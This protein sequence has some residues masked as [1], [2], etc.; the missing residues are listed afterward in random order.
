M[1]T[2][3]VLLAEIRRRAE[4]WKAESTRRLNQ[5]RPDPVLC[6]QAWAHRLEYSNLLSWSEEETA[7][8]AGA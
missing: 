3:E 8:G 5:A 2:V 7:K 6:E 1:I 4:E